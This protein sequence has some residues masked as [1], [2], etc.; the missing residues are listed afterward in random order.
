MTSNTVD[1]KLAGL[2]IDAVDT[3][4]LE[5]RTAPQSKDRI[6]AAN[7]ILDRLGYGRT[8][9]AQ[10]DQADREIRNALEAVESELQ[11]HGH[12][13]KAILQDGVVVLDA[14]PEGYPPPP[15]GK[16]EAEPEAEAPIPDPDA[17][18]EG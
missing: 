14:L 18:V 16:E 9:R 6:A 2:A 13:T 12:D 7:S 11:S 17:E 5:M 10:A 15:G 3:L 8:T 1:T 4:R